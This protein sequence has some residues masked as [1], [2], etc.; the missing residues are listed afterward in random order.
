M[1]IELNYGRGMLPLDL[2]DDWDVTV[3]GKKP[4]AALADPVA[5]VEAALAAPLGTPSLAEAARG[6]KLSTQSGVPCGAMFRWSTRRGFV[7]R[8]RVF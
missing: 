5:A 4:M 7:L 3:I 1:R 8:F 2:P 6:P